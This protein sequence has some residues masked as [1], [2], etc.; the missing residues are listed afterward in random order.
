MDL[1][2][3][4]ISVVIF[5]I[6]A[7]L[8]WLITSLTVRERPFEERMEEQRR[9]EQ[10][11][12]GGG[13]KPA[14]I[15]K[16]KTKKKNKKLKVGEREVESSGEKTEHIAKTKTTKMV[17]LEIDP[18]VIETSLSEPPVTI[19]EKKSK[20]GRGV[21][22]SPTTTMKSILTNKDDKSYVLKTDKAPELKHRSVRKDEIDLKHER[23]G[24]KADMGSK[25]ST[26][27]VN[28]FHSESTDGS[29]DIPAAVMST[30]L[31]SDQ[32]KV[33]ANESKPRKQRPELDSTPGD[34]DV[35][36]L[37][38]VAT[39][40]PVSND[41]TVSGMILGAVLHLY[42]HIILQAFPL[43]YLWTCDQ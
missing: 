28:G 12:L 1:Q 21:P 9:M 15:K 4:L 24:R 29:D 40:K 17:E 14:G 3:F 30:R 43:S 19:T 23:E 27:A 39:K 18:E 31:P 2:T 32:M 5:I 33:P 38:N 26:A 10:V 13:G 35:P 7:L 11:L 42:V 34:G 22:G 25:M 37:A 36:R 20:P 16:D 41:V 8:I 6:L